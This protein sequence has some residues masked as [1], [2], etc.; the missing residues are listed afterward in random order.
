MRALV[1]L[2]LGAA[3]VAAWLVSRGHRDPRLWPGALAAESVRLRSQLEEAVTA[4]R[5]AARE[6][7]EQLERELAE[8]GGTT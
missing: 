3:G 5:R 7:E 1:G 4:G 6:R 2:A 8:A